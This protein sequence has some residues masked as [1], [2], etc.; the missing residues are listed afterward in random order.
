VPFGEFFP[1]PDFVRNWM[2]MM[3]L[4]YSDFERGG[5][6]QEPL[7][8]GGHP[9]GASI[10]YEDVFPRVIRPPLPEATLLVNVSNDAWFGE[11]IAPH[12]HLEIAR[13]RSLESGREMLRATNTGVS[14][15]ID[16]QGRVRER[17]PQFETD[18]LVGEFQ[19]REGATPFVLTGNWINV[20]VFL[21]LI[22]LGVWLGRVRGK[23]QSFC[24]RSGFIRDRGSVKAL[25]ADE[26]APTTAYSRA[27]AR[28]SASMRRT[29]D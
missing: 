22:G 14:A 18:A 2:R 1:V 24:C 29:T 7:T 12:Q 4:P 8:I 28:A 26:S 5:L 21:L 9:V 13:M 27:S 11:S 23:G 16:H 3:N 25:I 17:L 6:D 15:I 20:P 19:H 10:C